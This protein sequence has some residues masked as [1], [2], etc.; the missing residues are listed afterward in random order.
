MHRLLGSLESAVLP[1]SRE[2]FHSDPLHVSFLLGRL[3]GFWGAHL[4]SRR[5]VN[6]S[7]LQHVSRICLFLFLPTVSQGVPA[8]RHS[9]LSTPAS[10]PG[11]SWSPSPVPG[12]WTV[13]DVFT[14][15]TPDR[16]F[17]SYLVAPVRR[18]G[19]DTITHPCFESNPCAWNGSSAGLCR[20]TD[21]FNIASVL[22]ASC[23]RLCAYFLNSVSVSPASSG[24]FST[25]AYT[26]NIDYAT[27]E[28][29]CQMLTLP[30]QSA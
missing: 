13:V 22:L 14:P 16:M 20:C 15:D 4:V 8:K 11:Q 29:S 28:R 23:A 18:P 2:A 10:C 19:Q 6:P 5:F 25:C 9:C 27:S 3:H 17:C 26:L 7:R 1:F 30:P 21:V 12:L 24:Q